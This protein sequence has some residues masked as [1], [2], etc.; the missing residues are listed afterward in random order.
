MA[1]EHD[2]NCINEEPKILLQKVSETRADVWFSPAECHVTPSGLD[3]ICNDLYQRSH[4]AILVD[5]TDLNYGAVTV[6]QNPAIKS[7]IDLEE[8]VRRLVDRLRKIYSDTVP[9]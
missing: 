2:Y 7:N 4:G 1:A 9:Y 3:G 5:V 8:A 6:Q